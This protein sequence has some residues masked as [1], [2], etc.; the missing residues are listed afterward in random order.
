[1]KKKVL[2]IGPFFNISGYS[3]H[4]RLLADALLEK[5]DSLDI[6]MLATQ[7]AKSSSD[8]SYVEKYAPL[9]QKTQ[10]HF[11]ELQKDQVPMNSAFDCSFQVR[12]PN[13]FE[14]ITNYDIGV[15]A[16]L[17]TTKA[18]T[19]WIQ[20]CNM[21]QKILVVSEHSKT[22]LKNA[23]NPQTGE[24]IRT[25]IEVIPFYN[26]LTN[27]DESFEG[28]K[29]I[30]TPVNFLTVS[31]LAPRKNFYNLV[32]WFVEEFKEEE[33]VGLIAKLHHV[34]NCTMDYYHVKRRIN[35]ILTE[36]G[37]QNRKCKI[38]LIHGNLSEKEMQSLYNNETIKAYVTTTHGEGFG[39]PMF[40]AV[41]SDIPVI[42]PAWSGHMDFL[43]APVVNETSGKSKVKNLFLK[44]KFEISPVKDK[45]LM[46][47]LITKECEWCYPDGN[48]FKKNLRSAITGEK[49]HRS[50]SKILGEH[51]RQNFSKDKVFKMCQ[52]IMES[53]PQTTKPVQSFDIQVT[54]M[55]NEIAGL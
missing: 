46:P 42:A 36:T 54:N 31:Q 25:P 43:S 32:K 16:A 6:Y 45:H 52:N 20:N 26:S 19:E 7:W 4:A 22:N 49:L 51:I 13:E 53:V 47:G 39:V 23:R 35:Q 50:N 12:P 17:E 30:T 14:N 48:S 2:L 18:P 10:Q 15:T 41:C 28:Y 33:N 38:H 5:Q 37:L 27:G 34:N 21:M 55:F 44:T 9:L 11:Q 24:T 40:N 1:M 8:S 29:N 3:D